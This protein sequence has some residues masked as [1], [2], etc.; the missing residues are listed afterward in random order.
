M[1][2]SLDAVGGKLAARDRD[3]RKRRGRLGR[4]G[5]CDGLIGGATNGHGGEEG[6][7]ASSGCRWAGT[8]DGR[9]VFAG[10]RKRIDRARDAA[11]GSDGNSGYRRDLRGR[12][13]RC[14]GMGRHGHRRIV[15]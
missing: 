1:T 15:E 4:T 9:G 14:C 7:H 10:Y 6:S 11:G 2:A 8:L 5:W 12:N 3:R 13:A